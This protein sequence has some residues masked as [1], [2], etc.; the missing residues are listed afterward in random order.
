MHHHQRR[1]VCSCELF[2]NAL[3]TRIFIAARGKGNGEALAES[4]SACVFELLNS[5]VETA[6][7]HVARAGHEVLD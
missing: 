5:C 6:A 7:E 3:D 4:L 2:A 1:P